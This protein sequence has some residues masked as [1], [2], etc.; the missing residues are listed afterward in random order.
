MSLSMDSSSSPPQPARSRRWIWIA[1][2][3][4][5]AITLLAG[6]GAFVVAPRLCGVTEPQRHGLDCD[7]PLPA[8]ATYLGLLPAPS[9]VG[10]STKTYDFH[11]PDTTEQ[12]IKDFYAQRLPSS[13]WKCVNHD[14]PVDVT[15]F[16]GTRGVGSHP[17][18]LAARRR[19]WNWRSACPRSPGTWTP[20]ALSARASLQSDYAMMRPTA[21]HR[22]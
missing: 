5:L 22:M 17:W 15:A 2:I 4:A 8:Y 14:D 20:R 1:L 19:A 18:R 13:G 7:I 16:Q 11:V 10:V 6:V 21:D 12:A 9:A 3:V